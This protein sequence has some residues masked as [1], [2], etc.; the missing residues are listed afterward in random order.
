MPRSGNIY[1]FENVV[2]LFLEGKKIVR[3]NVEI[4]AALR[5]L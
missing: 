3:A 2:A 5:I 4:T 1:I